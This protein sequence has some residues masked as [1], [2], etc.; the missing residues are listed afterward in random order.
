MSNLIYKLRK[1]RSAVL[2]VSILFIILL[3]AVLAPWLA[4]YNPWEIS[5]DTFASPSSGH[6]FGT[7]NLGRDMFSSVIYGTRVTLVIGVLAALISIIIG[8]IF[9]SI[10]G[11]YGGKV[12]I[13]M[14]RLVEIFQ[15]IPGFFLALTVV[16]IFG[17][18]IEKL[19]IVIGIISWPKSARMVRGQFLSLKQ[20]EFVQADKVLGFS[21]LHII[22][23]SILPNVAPSL[24]II[25]SF[26]IAMAILIE[27][28]L[29]F[30]GLGDPSHITWG[31]LLFNAQ[32]YFMSAWWLSIFPGL[33]IFV[34]V[35][36]F[37]L[38]GDGMND[39]L[40]PHL[41]ER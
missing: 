22:F 6:W 28:G 36:G 12:D 13:L 9:G 8:S 25:V 18:G 2:G 17:G 16:A 33:A 41:K 27:A 10:S 29:S 21:N 30:L 35:L 23:R 37:N 20:Q 1:N 39:I 19:I 32:R 40:N 3:T 38:F 26:D 11:F 15:S 34:T 14:M 4:P 7:D 24:I 31:S 5:R